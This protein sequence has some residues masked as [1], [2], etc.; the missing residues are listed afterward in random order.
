MS[1]DKGQAR[2][3]ALWRE[4]GWRAR[5][6][7]PVS[8][9]Y[10]LITLIRRSLYAHGLLTIHRLPVP[11]VVVGNVVVGGAGKTPTVLALLA[12]WKAQGWRPGVVSRG[13]GRQGQDVME[14][15]AETPAADSGDEPA[16]IQRSAAVPVFVGASRAEAARALLSAHPT[17]NL[18]LCDDGLQHLALGRDLS[19]AVFDNRGVGNGWLLPA[20]LLREPWPPR[21]HQAFQ[22]DVTLQ[23]TAEGQTQ[24]T[25]IPTTRAPLYQ[26]RRR[27]ADHVRGP[28]GEHAELIAL[29]GSPLVAMAGIALP[30]VF[31]EMLRE[32]GLTLKETVALP[33]HADNAT[34][35]AAL[36]AC[37]ATLICTEKDAVKL[38]PL[39]RA[40]PEATRPSLWT[41]PLELRPEPGFFEDLD[42]RLE[43]LVS[44]P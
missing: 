1:Q 15:R 24:R 28:N 10:G 14:V 42:Q 33:D 12:H 18:L 7:W 40:T 29:R 31:F 39:W 20:G 8:R 27:L 4:R 11:V 5:L 37:S 30:E 43:K 17:V 22:P 26:A 34:L 35:S 6:L 13:H 23:H 19:V 3:Q 38:F 41:V 21:K 9:L 44:R 16:L 32:R 36:S 2:W 25:R